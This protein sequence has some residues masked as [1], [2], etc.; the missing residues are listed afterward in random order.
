M[1]IISRGRLV[2]AALFLGFPV[3]ADPMLEVR[4]DT[5]P[6]LVRWPMAEE[7]EVCLTWNH[8]VTGGK[9]ADCFVQSSGQLVLRRSYLHDFAAGLGE[10]PGRGTLVSA[11]EGGY[12]IERIDAPVADNTLTLWIGAA[13]VDHKLHLGGQVFSLSARAPRQKA[14][15]RLTLSTDD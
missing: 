9:V 3:M 7:A 2:L 15:L 4:L 8:S 6:V 12:W 1:T 5:G 10:V 11:A 14:Q 13:S